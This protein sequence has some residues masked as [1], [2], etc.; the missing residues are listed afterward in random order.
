MRSCKAFLG[1]AYALSFAASCTAAQ[2]ADESALQVGPYNK[3]HDRHYGHD[4]LYPD[5]GAIFRDVPHGSSLVNYAGLTY[6]FYNG[7]WLEQRGPAF[8]VVMPPIGLVV[9]ALPEFVT[10]FKSG[11]ETYYYANDVYYLARPDLGGYEV[12]NDPIDMEPTPNQAGATHGVSMPAS[13]STLAVTAVPA[14]AVAP[15]L[16]VGSNGGAAT[17][18]G[19]ASALGRTAVVGASTVA[20]AAPTMMTALDTKATASAVAVPAVGRVATTSGTG[21]ATGVAGAGSIQ[22]IRGTSVANSTF[23]ATSAQ[24][25]PSLESPAASANVAAPVI[26]TASVADGTSSVTGIPAAVPGVMI[27]PPLPL[28]RTATTDTAVP[29]GSATG[30]STT[31]TTLGLSASGGTVLATNASGGTSPTSFAPSAGTA[32]PPVAQSPAA[33]A[34]PALAGASLAA[35]RPTAVSLTAAPATAAAT[36]PS[37]SAAASSGA[38]GGAHITPYPRNGQSLDQQA[39]DQ[40]DCYHYGVTQSGYDPITKVG[41]AAGRPEQAEFE[42]ARSA[43]FEA[44]GYAFR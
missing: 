2:G 23:G 36:V 26:R 39:R 19:T 16:A 14:V 25:S 5:R 31:G 21:A 27:G 7:I 41:A 37:S 29:A 12:V 11:D 32:T 6:R 24:G 38:A 13:G 17:V 35:P 15:A 9:P 4:R 1:I 28:G 43:C 44:R 40:Y 34:A 33:L 20:G 30:G 3:H 10:S 8:I 42:R 18:A 22:M